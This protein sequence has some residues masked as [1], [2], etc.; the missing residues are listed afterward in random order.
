VE[1]S[2]QQGAEELRCAITGAA[3]ARLVALVALRVGN[4]GTVRWNVLS[5]VSLSGVCMMIPVTIIL[6][7]K[8]DVGEFEILC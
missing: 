4:G 3:H 6:C 2:G 5:D 1:W 8:Y 7:S